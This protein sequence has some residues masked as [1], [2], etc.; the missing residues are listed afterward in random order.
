MQEYGGDLGHGVL[1]RRAVS[2]ESRRV[3]KKKK[4]TVWRRRRSIDDAQRNTEKLLLFFFF[5]FERFDA[6]PTP[7]R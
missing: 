5:I 3:K 7:I 2:I 6:I 1:S 4:N